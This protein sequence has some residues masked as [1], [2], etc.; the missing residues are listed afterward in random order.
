MLSNPAYGLRPVGFIDDDPT[1]VGKQING[2]E[3][4][5]GL[6]GLEDAIAKTGAEAVVISTP[7]IPE[8]RV[9]QARRSCDAAG[10]RLLRM[11]IGFDEA[12]P[13]VVAET[14]AADSPDQSPAWNGN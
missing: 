9:L 10:T 13:A 11:N 3:I 14:V 1:R 5:F 12:L 6:D 2:F 8:A 7:K 4:L